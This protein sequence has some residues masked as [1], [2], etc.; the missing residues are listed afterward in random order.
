MQRLYTEIT[1]HYVNSILFDDYYARWHGLSEQKRTQQLTSILYGAG[2]LHQHYDLPSWVPDWTFQWYQAPI[3]CRADSNLGSP[4]ARDGWSDG[5]RSKY[6]AGGEKL[7]TFE[8]LTGVRNKYRL[9]LSAIIIDNVVE[10]SEAAPVFNLADEPITS[11]PLPTSA[12][13]L[14]TKVFAYGRTFFTTA[15]SMTG[16]ATSG[17]RP[18]DFV[19][20]L[21]GGDVPVIIRR[22]DLH[23][24]DEGFLL[25]CECFVRSSSVMS[26]ELVQMGK[27]RAHDIVLL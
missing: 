6:R 23:S 19:A 15:T 14:D 20:L 16:V 2:K 18:G 4:T 13:F 27:L 12:A 8:I 26:G 21:V 1:I 25:L 7:E 11:D 24:E 10:T 17:I 9:R 3:W 5:I 22:C